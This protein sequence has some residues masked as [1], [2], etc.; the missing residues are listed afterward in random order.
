[1]MQG[2]SVGHL[3]VIDPAYHGG[4]KVVCTAKDTATCDKGYKPTDCQ[5]YPAYPAVDTHGNITQYIKGAKCPLQP[6]HLAVHLAKVERDVRAQI[7]AQP[8]LAAFYAHVEMVGYESP[9][10]LPSVLPITARDRKTKAS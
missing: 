7:K 5:F 10:P 9:R 6:E 1:M 8:E 2:L 4:E 3:E